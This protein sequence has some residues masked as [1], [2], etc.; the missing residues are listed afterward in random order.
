MIIPI[1]FSSILLSNLFLSISKAF[2][3]ILICDSWFI[4][5]CSH[6]ISHL[7]INNT[8]VIFHV[9]FTRLVGRWKPSL[10]KFSQCQRWW[11]WRW[12]QRPMGNRSKLWLVKKMYLHEMKILL[13]RVHLII[14]MIIFLHKL[15]NYY[16]SFCSI[17]SHIIV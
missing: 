15:R 1:E 4:Y 3:I 14:M 8:I 7:Y 6:H 16:H 2:T 13:C 5:F 17:F 11:R 10:G 12:R 9:Q